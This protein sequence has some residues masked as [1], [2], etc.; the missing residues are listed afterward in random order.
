GRPVKVYYSKDEHFGAFVLRLGSRFCG[1][2]G[3][4]KDGT[5]TAVSG[6]WLVDTGAFSDMAQAQIAVGCGE[7]QLMLR[8]QN[9]DFKTKLICTNRSASGIVRG[10]GGHEL[11]A[12]LSPLL[13]EIMKKASLDPVQFFKKNYVKPGEGYTWR[14]GKHWVCRGTD[15]SGT[16]DCGAQAFGWKDKWRGWL[17]PTETRGVKRIGVGVGIHGNTD[18]GEDESEAYVRLNPDATAT[19]HVSISE[20]GMGQRSNLCK[21]AAEVLQIPIERVNITPADTLVNP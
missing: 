17:Q 4:K 21:M 11:N 6:E 1:K 14:E 3:V 8:C 16:I 19:I 15:Y 5:V 18:V 7:A 20:S 12:A 13:Q 9:W 10:F 2:I